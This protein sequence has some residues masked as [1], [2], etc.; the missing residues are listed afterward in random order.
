MAN[1]RILPEM[2]MPDPLAGAIP[3]SHR[4][5]HVA[6]MGEHNDSEDCDTSVRRDEVCSTFLF[7]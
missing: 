6:N 2:M 7:V 3:A 4:R 1:I 5:F